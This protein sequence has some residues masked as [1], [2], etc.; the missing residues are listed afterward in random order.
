V[1]NPGKYNAG[2]ASPAQ[3]TSC[4]WCGSEVAPGRDVEVDKGSGR[5]FV[6]C[7]DKKGRCDFSK[8]KSSKLPHPGIPV[9]V[10]DEEIYRPPTMIATV[11]KFAMMAWRG[12]V[13]T[14]FGRVGQECER[15]G[16]LWQGADCN[17]NHQAGKGFLLRR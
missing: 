16:L 17:G 9:L 6:Y 7:G 4:P 5:T 3:L 2:A 1:R 14:L 11:D 15:H 10:V 8:G 12:Q 13:R